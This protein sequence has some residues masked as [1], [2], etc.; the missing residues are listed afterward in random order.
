ME[1]AHAEP[2][3]QAL[4][5]PDAIFMPN[6][7]ETV[8]EFLKVD[9]NKPED[10]VRLLAS[11]FRGYADMCN[12]LA[13]WSE[14]AGCAA[15]EIQGTLVKT[16]ADRVKA[17]YDPQCTR[18]VF[19]ARNANVP[20]MS[21][22]V[23]KPLWRSVLYELAEVHKADAVLGLAL[24]TIEKLGH[25]DELATILLGFKLFNQALVQS[26]SKM[27]GF[28][29]QKLVEELPKFKKMCAQSPNTYLY[30]QLVLLRAVETT[31]ASGVR[32]MRLFWEL[33]DHVVAEHKGSKVVSRLGYL[34]MGV[35][36]YKELA[37][38]LF[39]MLE[40]GKTNPADMSRIHRAFTQQEN[41]P[42][43]WFLHN[44][45]LLEM[46]VDDLFVTGREVP[47]SYLEKYVYCLA[48][49]TSPS[50]E[51]D[52]EGEGRDDGNRLAEV[53]KA[54]ETASMVAKKNFFGSELDRYTPLLHHYVASFPVVCMGL[55]SWIRSNM[56]D[57]SY[58]EK[59]TH[60]LS[61]GRF[62]SLVLK[63]AATQ[64]KLRLHCVDVLK[65]AY[66]AV[67][68][69]QTEEGMAGEAARVKTELL[70]GVVQLLLTDDGQ[71]AMAIVQWME[72]LVSRASTD[73]AIVRHFVK[74]L[75]G[76]VL[77][78]FSAVFVEF[79][80]SLLAHAIPENSNYTYVQQLMKIFAVPGGGPSVVDS[81][82]QEAHKTAGLS[83]KARS[84]LAT[85]QTR[86]APPATKM[87]QATPLT[88]PTTSAST[89][90]SA[91]K[92]AAVVKS[93]TVIKIAN[94][95]PSLIS[96]KD[97]PTPTAKKPQ[98]EKKKTA[99][100]AEKKKQVSETKKTSK[101]ERVVDEEDEDGDFELDEEEEQIVAKKNLTARR[102]PSRASK[103]VDKKKT[104]F[105][106]PAA[107]LAKGT[108]KTTTT[109]TATATTKPAKRNE[110]AFLEEAFLEFSDE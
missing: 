67:E 47:S 25:Q 48:Y 19:Q 50:A 53:I 64:I 54:I 1:G 41:R 43:V 10:A 20:W 107:L 86:I 33:H 2:L 101:R 56:C 39:V 31:G 45:K 12:L 38:G 91:P 83:D 103:P 62:V 29:E 15:E 60:S 74:A 34:L 11:G 68:T 110:D 36:Q 55:L 22:M 66:E 4:S 27:L 42:P 108:K 6:A 35:L 93:S 65:T 105:T 59:G 100:V 37:A 99:V 3:S 71:V 69:S 70:D 23:T 49:A 106:V 40:N 92:P 80:A 78:P 57:R 96:R 77:T 24:S 7:L 18:G 102:Q 51:E 52:G 89:V 94:L 90:S 73:T 26:V 13:A 85:V 14:D 98:P 87:T 30:T 79:V 61:L 63:I 28:S 8:K 109:T 32:L 44:G 9:G 76:C 81:F 84:L 21:F 46:L 88:K 58:Y 104:K 16:V 5:E 97:A 95:N 72:G 17:V 82:L 75:L